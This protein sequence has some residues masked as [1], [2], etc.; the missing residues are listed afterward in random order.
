[1]P[2]ENFSSGA[3]WEPVAGYSRAVRTGNEIHVSGTTATEPDGGIP[4]PGDFTAQTRQT[5]EKIRT[6][7]ERAGAGLEHVVRTRMYVTDIDRWEDVARVHGE[8]FGEMGAIDDKPRSATAIAMGPV[9]CMSVTQ[10]EFM[11]MLL[12]RPQESIDLLKILFDRLR[13]ANRRLLDYVEAHP[14]QDD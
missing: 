2:R 4:S 14:P 5:L 11:E 12:N 9:V 8:F 3:P 6:A 13:D 10:E 7:L 1:M